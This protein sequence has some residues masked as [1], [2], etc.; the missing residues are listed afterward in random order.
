MKFDEKMDF[1]KVSYGAKAL[2]P[3]VE[4]IDVRK[5][6]LYLI[7]RALRNG[8]CVITDDN[9]VGRYGCIG[10]ACKIGD[11]AFY[12]VTEDY[13]SVNEYMKGRALPRVVA[14]VIDGLETLRDEVDEDEFAY[15]LA[16]L[17]VSVQCAA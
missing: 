3:E 10:V 4:N 2:L 17:R 15:Y 16:T 9:T 7:P 11:N 5:E 13:D 12:F 8:T 6:L 1:D 14:D